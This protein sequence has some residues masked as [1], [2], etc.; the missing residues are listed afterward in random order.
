M[1]ACNS[2]LEVSHI[3][4]HSTSAAS[5][6]LQGII[7]LFG[8]CRFFGAALSAELRLLAVTALLISPRSPEVNFS[9]VAPPLP[10]YASSL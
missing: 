5:K 8:F 6:S 9:R 7:F 4:D 10:T 1:I 3:F 2:L